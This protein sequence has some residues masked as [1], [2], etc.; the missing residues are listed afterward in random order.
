MRNLTA[1]ICLTIAVLL[2]SF[3]VSWSLENRVE[4]SCQHVVT[5]FLRTHK[6][7]K[8]TPD[9][10]SL[11]ILT[12]SKV[13]IGGGK[14]FPYNEKGNNIYW[15]GKYDK[16][17]SPRLEFS[18]NRVTGVYKLTLWTY[19]TITPDFT[20]GRTLYNSLK[21]ASKPNQKI[22][23]FLTQEYLCQKTKKIF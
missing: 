1:T 10:E 11:T 16:K 19:P 2:G 23:P 12:D 9:K 5:H 3:G 21:E 20:N 22:S 6:S 8:G 15:T 17:L 14:Y 13:V 18:L 7:E 4:L